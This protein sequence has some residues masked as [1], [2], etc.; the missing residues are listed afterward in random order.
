MRKH[1]GRASIAACVAAVG[2][3]AMDGPTRGDLEDAAAD[4]AVDE[5]RRRVRE[6]ARAIRESLDASAAAVDRRELLERKRSTDGWLSPMHL[7]R[8]AMRATVH[9][10]AC[11]LLA[12]WRVEW[13]GGPVREEW[14][15]ADGARLARES[16]DA[17]VPRAGSGEA[18]RMEAVSAA[19]RWVACDAP[20]TCAWTVDGSWGAEGP[21]VHGRCWWRLPVAERV[22]VDLP[23]A[24]DGVDLWWDDR[25]ARHLDDRGA[26]H[27]EAW[28]AGAVFCNPPGLYAAF[29]SLRT[30]A[31]PD[32]AC[33]P[34]TASPGAAGAGVG[35]AAGPAAFERT[36]TVRSADGR[37]L[38]EER[39]RWQGG[40][41]HEVRMRVGPLRIVHHA[42][43]AVRIATEVDGRV[44]ES[45][46]HRAASE[47]TEFADGADVTVSFRAPRDGVD[48][49]RP[50]AGRAAAVPDRIRVEVG[51]TPVVEASVRWCRLGQVDAPDALGSARQDTLRRESA[52]HRALADRVEAAIRS[53]D[54]A[55]VTAAA[56]AIAAM[57]A[58]ADAPPSALGD[59][60]HL[61]R[62]RLSAAGMGTG[63]IDALAAGAPAVVSSRPACGGG[64]PSASERDV[65]HRVASGTGRNAC[66]CE[67]PDARSLCAAV[68]H[69]MLEAGMDGAWRAC[70]AGMTCGGPG[71][72]RVRTDDGTA[73]RIAADLGL[74]LRAG[75]IDLGDARED[76]ACEGL[77]SLVLGVAERPLPDPA[78]AA[79]RMVALDAACAGAREALRR[80]LEL[81]ARA[82]GRLG[83]HRGTADVLDAFDALVTR[84]RSLVG[85]AF[86]E[87]HAGDGTGP[88]D[89]AGSHA[90]AAADP[91]VG[92][93]VRHESERVD[94]L[95]A[96][97]G[98]DVGRARVQVAHRRIAAAAMRAAE[99]ATAPTREAG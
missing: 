84:Q 65:A 42:E 67:D 26:G 41:L 40:R 14:S 29:D 15:H 3:M 22:R 13:R 91:A 37:A 79:R 48:A 4:R 16:L 78:S 90:R 49:C 2:C 74:A 7:V 25:G 39:W 59:E 60:L 63:T 55:G 27:A 97:A 21:V 52:A 83:G 72:G 66:D 81:D 8:D 44:T 82:H 34:V 9:G 80:A 92:A 47:L 30:A 17:W 71:R 77:A 19:H 96:T 6:E 85:N 45:S 18:L 46:E 35:A 62:E 89:P 76:G 99:R 20:A 1:R 32:A 95:L 87:P 94:A 24:G 38:R 23:L 86:L 53:R 12:A 73:R 69:A 28:P 58:S 54:G 68:D 11:D 43:R 88:D 75:A 98:E 33:V 93:A 61:L 31:A 64:E 5:M 10:A 70:V 36:R 51:S 57:H 50:E 56:R